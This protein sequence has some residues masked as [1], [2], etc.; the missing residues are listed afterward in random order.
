MKD[1]LQSG[2]NLIYL[3]T[4]ALHGRVPETEVMKQMD[5]AEVYRM[6]KFHALTSMSYMALDAY[7]KA[8]PEEAAGFDAQLLTDWKNAKNKAIYKQMMMDAEREAILSHMEEQ[9]I[10][11]MP[12]KGI[13]LKELYP[14]SGMREMVDNDILFDIE[15]RKHI[16]EFM[17]DRGYKDEHCGGPVHDMY[18]KMPFYNFEMHVMLYARYNSQLFYDY[19]KDVKARLIKDEGNGY[20]YHFS[21]EDFY[22]FVLIHAYKHYESGG[23]GIRTLLDL[24]VYTQAKGDTLDWAYLQGEMD[25]LGI[26]GFE[27]SCRELAEK[28]FDVA[29][30]DCALAAGVTDYD[31]ILTDDDKTDME[32]FLSAGS[33]GTTRIAFTQRLGR[34]VD[35]EEDITLGVRLKYLY[36][37]L[38]PEMGFY[39]SA[40]PV[41]YRHK[42]LLPFYMAYRLSVKAFRRRDA[43]WNEVKFIL[44]KKEK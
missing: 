27:K 25:K 23:F 7:V 24:Y 20:G 31:A 35:D 38:F 18:L 6:A 10:W 15:Y 30:C 36:K 5:L 9:G 3:V 17:V 4:C 42:V 28:L 1:I 33:K 12:L 11:Y 41:V 34:M 44:G 8:N 32:F 14:K 19:Y 2:Y 22:I 37:R 43:I 21:D 39:E 13:F 40:A 26:A 29:R 16:R